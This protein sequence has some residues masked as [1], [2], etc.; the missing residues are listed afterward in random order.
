MPCPIVDLL[1]DTLHAASSRVDPDP[2]LGLVARSTIQ[3][4]LAIAWAPSY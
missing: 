1:R 3:W 4:T 2:G